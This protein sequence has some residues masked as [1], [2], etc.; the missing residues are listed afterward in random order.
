MDEKKLKVAFIHPDLGI[1]GAER[2]VL[3]VA[4]ALSDEGH[5]VKFITNHFDKTHAFDELKNGEYPVE[6]YGDWLP[7]SVFGKFHA[8]CAYMRMIYL[9]I[10]YILFFRNKDKPDLYFIDLIP[11][12]IPLLKLAN[13]NVI[14]YC[15]HPD[16]LASTPGGKL[17]KIYRTPID[18]LEQKATG[19]A[20][21]ILVNSEYTASVFRK[22]FPQITKPIHILYPTIASSY[23]KTV[24]DLKTATPINE[25]VPQIKSEGSNDVV[26]LSLNRFHPV[27]KTGVS[28]S[29]YG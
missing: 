20:D 10:V 4:S 24:E 2:L 5:K 19:K 1:G 22:T 7:R 13:E 18:W 26:F 12:A 9:S 25:L 11:I 27:K 8:L 29:C 16:L 6:V 3:D 28:Y 17:K 15:H 23:Q 21:V 14:Y